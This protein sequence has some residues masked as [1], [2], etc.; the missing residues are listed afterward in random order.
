MS[1]R[2]ILELKP[3]PFAHFA[4]QS[5]P[6]TIQSTLDEVTTSQNASIKSSSTRKKRKR[7]LPTAPAVVLS[8]DE[9]PSVPPTKP[10]KHHKDHAE[11]EFP[12]FS[13]RSKVPFGRTDSRERAVSSPPIIHR[14]SRVHHGFL[15]IS[16]ITPVLNFGSN[17]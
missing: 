4:K 11:S 16:Q 3:N 5:P 12:N 1:K 14:E 8:A 13:T 2:P 10:K 9:Q 6:I 7:D 15:G 17:Y